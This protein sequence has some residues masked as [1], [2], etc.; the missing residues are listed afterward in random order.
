MEEDDDL[1]RRQQE[2]EAANKASAD[3]LS[4]EEAEEAERQARKETERKEREE[5]LAQHQLAQQQQ[6][7]KNAKKGGIGNAF[8]AQLNNAAKNLTGNIP[9]MGAKRPK[10]DADAPPEGFDSEADAAAKKEYAEIE[11]AQV[12]YKGRDA[13]ERTDFNIVNHDA[14][15]QKRGEIKTLRTVLEKGTL[16][17]RELTSQELAAMD[18]E[19]KRKKKELEGATFADKK[20]FHKQ[21]FRKIS[22]RMERKAPTTQK[23]VDKL[24]YNLEKIPLLKETRYLNFGLAASRTYFM[25]KNIINTSY[26]EGMI[27]PFAA[28]ERATQQWTTRQRNNMEM[29]SAATLGFLD[30]FLVKEGSGGAFIFRD[31]KRKPVYDLTMSMQEA[32][33]L[34]SGKNQDLSS[35]FA[36]YEKEIT[37]ATARINESFEQ[38]ERAKTLDNAVGNMV[39]SA[40][41]I[42]TFLDNQTNDDSSI[43]AQSCINYINGNLDSVSEKYDDVLKEGDTFKGEIEEIKNR[44]EDAKQEALDAIDNTNG[45]DNNARNIQ[46]MNIMEDLARKVTSNQEYAKENVLND[47]Y[48]NADAVIAEQE[49]LIESASKTLEEH[50]H[51]AGK[52]T[53]F[54]DR[55]LGKVN[56]SITKIVANP[57]GQSV[58]TGGTLVARLAAYEAEE[59]LDDA[60]KFA[61]KFKQNTKKAVETVENQ[62]Q[63]RQEVIKSLK[64]A[65][66]NGNRGDIEKYMRQ[67]KTT[68]EG[69]SDAKEMSKIFFSDKLKNE[70]DAAMDGVQEATNSFKEACFNS[71]EQIA[72]VGDGDAELGYR[73]IGFYEREKNGEKYKLGRYQ[74]TNGIGVIERTITEGHTDKADKLKVKLKAELNTIL[75]RKKLI[76]DVFRLT[77]EINQG[78]NKDIKRITERESALHK[79]YDTGSEWHGL[80]VDIDPNK[81]KPQ[82]LEEKLTDLKDRYNDSVDRYDYVVRHLESFSVPYDWQY[83]EESNLEYILGYKGD[84]HKFKQWYDI[85]QELSKY[86]AEKSTSNQQKF[87]IAMLKNKDTEGMIQS[88]TMLALGYVIAEAGKNFSDTANRTGGIQ[89]GLSGSMDKKYHELMSQ[90]S[91]LDKKHN[92]EP[93]LS[94]EVM[95]RINHLYNAQTSMMSNALRTE[96][97][98][99]WQNIYRR[100]FQHDQFAEADAPQGDEKWGAFK[101]AM[102]V[103]WEEFTWGFR[104]GQEVAYA[105]TPVKYFIHQP[106]KN[107][108]NWIGGL[109][110]EKF[111]GTTD[112]INKGVNWMGYLIVAPFSL[113]MGVTSWGYRAVKYGAME[114]VRARKKKLS[115]AHEKVAID[116]KQFEKQSFS[117]MKSSFV[118]SVI[119]NIKHYDPKRPPAQSSPNG[120]HPQPNY[121]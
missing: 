51:E 108:L 98:A 118:D 26:I 59:K 21:K 110:G 83:W 88:M 79:L 33:D 11:S 93:A 66:S 102:K 23:S 91:D 2:G 9:G 112:I 76:D 52:V 28:Y 56:D 71:D 94:K 92:K 1:K 34:V 99:T 54:L 53:E 62:I 104:Q 30:S 5:Q 4:L 40:K 42:D 64:N 87:L 46:L 22:Y 77:Q 6:A 35:A 106:M 116:V 49:K 72:V 47:L 32:G 67:V 105:N 81:P 70:Y 78:H 45:M 82:T 114:P 50:I 18:A 111:K 43:T 63:R 12:H 121:P 19:L 119:G 58:L 101:Y 31:D 95:A 48:N 73:N 96:A 55:S 90:M 10:A 61:Q 29:S 80:A 13:S 44:I 109:G 68:L 20:T 8:S 38:I 85:G 86:D 84:S 75:E 69:H 60:T 37:A 65:L 15:R 27:D 117:K 7:Q 41:K 3:Q 103:G 57:K 14:F 25:S 74:E 17:D 89:K 120:T 107:T 16:N 97:S 36:T 115:R 100:L 39:A 24:F 113:A